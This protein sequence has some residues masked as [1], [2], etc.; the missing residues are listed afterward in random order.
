VVGGGTPVRDPRETMGHLG[1]RCPRRA[2]P[3]HQQ[4]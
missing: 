4:C 1:A 2:L 3:R